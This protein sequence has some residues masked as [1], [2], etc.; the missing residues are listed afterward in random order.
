MIP[1]MPV[2]DVPLLLARPRLPLQLP[3]LWADV[4]D[5]GTLAV[6]GRPAVLRRYATHCA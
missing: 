5:D 6:S 2:A 3:L 4:N 1:P